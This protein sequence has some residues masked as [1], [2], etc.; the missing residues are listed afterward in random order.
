MP[1]DLETSDEEVQK[2]AHCGLIEPGVHVCHLFQND[3]LQPCAKRCL[4]RIR[5]Q[6]MYN[7]LLQAVRD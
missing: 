6:C 7:H 4:T 1:E 5:V 3:G 2:V